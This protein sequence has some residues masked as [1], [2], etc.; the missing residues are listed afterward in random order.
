MHE[1]RDCVYVTYIYP[2]LF[3]VN[4]NEEIDFSIDEINNLSYDHSLLHRIVGT[5]SNIFNNRNIEYLICGDAAIGIKF[6]DQIP[7]DEVILYFNDLLCK[8][9]LG[10]LRVEAITNK[11]IVVGDI[12][13]SKSIWPVGFGESW[14]SHIHAE[15]RMKLVGVTDAI[16]LYQ[17]QNRTINIREIEK[18]LE[19]GNRIVNAIPNLSTFHLLNGITEF[20]YRNWSSSLTYLWIVVEEITD[21]LWTKNIVDKV[22]GVNAK[23]RKETLKDTRTYPMAVKQ[24]ML[25]Q[26][27]ILDKDIYD[28]IFLIRQARN[29]LIHDGTMITEDTA[30]LLYDSIMK[31]L[32][33]VTQQNDA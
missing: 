25:F 26:I 32:E 33:E 27:G 11:D 29:K 31:L 15:L 30:K 17:P 13:L 6:A 1:K 5:I 18:K 22:E 9:F 24:E 20:G 12:Y 8:I 3:V 19:E 23:R 4:D 14:N 10:G 16:L 7:K 28:S 2:L 21:F